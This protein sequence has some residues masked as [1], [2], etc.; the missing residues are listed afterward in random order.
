M[1][2][3]STRL[4]GACGFDKLSRESRGPT[5]IKISHWILVFVFI[6]SPLNVIRDQ[7]GLG[8]GGVWQCH[9]LNQPYTL[10]KFEQ[11]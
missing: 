2:L 10:K 4:P 9:N 11:I 3:R 7:L 1:R 6:L 8:W 5:R